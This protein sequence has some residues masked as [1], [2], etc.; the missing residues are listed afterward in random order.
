M[1]KVF[2]LVNNYLQYGSCELLNI[3]NL[4]KC[5]T[6]IA[7]IYCPTFNIFREGKNSLLILSEWLPES[8]YT[9]WGEPCP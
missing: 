2:L 5:T 6:N 8:S 1:D 9:I 4:E 7:W 3:L